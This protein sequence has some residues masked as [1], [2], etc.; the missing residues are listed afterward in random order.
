MWKKLLTTVAVATLCF[1]SA[2][3][4]QSP[5]PPQEG[6]V[7]QADYDFD[8]TIYNSCISRISNGS[9]P[10]YV[11]CIDQE[12]RRQESAMQFFYTELLKQEQYQKWNNGK[13]LASGNIKDMNDQYIAYR[14]RLCSMFAIGMMNFYQNIE[15]GRK[16]CMMKVNDEMLRRLQRFY[17]ESLADFSHFND[18]DPGTI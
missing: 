16:E 13:T 8:Q 3:A 14:D 5:N 7:I 6:S 15:W 12:L 11:G 10:A 17:G 2:G 9:G 18:F 1:S 4:Q